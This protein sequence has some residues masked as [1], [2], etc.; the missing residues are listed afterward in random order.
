MEFEVKITTMVSKTVK[1]N[2][3]DSAHAREIAARLDHTGVFANTRCTIDGKKY[4]ARVCCSVCGEMVP[5]FYTPDDDE[6]P[7]CLPCFN[8]IARKWRREN[9]LQPDF[10]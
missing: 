1:V 10:A 9:G 5:I 2:A 7:V 6:T 4:E 8:R 3:M